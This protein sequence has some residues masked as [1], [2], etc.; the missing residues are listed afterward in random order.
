MI[1]FTFDSIAKIMPEWEKEQE[2]LIFRLAT[3]SVCRSEAL[4]ERMDAT[5]AKG[6][7]GEAAGMVALHYDG[8]LARQVRVILELPEDVWEDLANQADDLLE[9]SQEES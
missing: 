3:A 2:R 1:Q 4:H 5:G 6:R 9:E 8:D 7:D